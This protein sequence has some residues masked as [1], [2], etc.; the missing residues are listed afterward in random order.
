MIGRLRQALTRAGSSDALAA[1]LRGT[2]AAPWAGSYIP[3][4][5]I[6]AMWEEAIERCSNA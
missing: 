5:V 6:D 4:E 3:D 1:R 2:E